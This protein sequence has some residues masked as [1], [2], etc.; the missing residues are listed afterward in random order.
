[1]K[2]FKRTFLLFLLII[3]VGFQEDNYERVSFYKLLANP[4]EYNGKKICLEGILHYR[5]ED[6]G[7]YPSQEYS[8]Y[9]ITESAFGIDYIKNPNVED[10]KGHQISL[11]D[12]NNKYVRISGVF[13]NNKHGHMGGFAGTIE[14]VNDVF[15]SINW[16]AQEKK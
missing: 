11:N 16:A 9:L 4:G 6:S 12:L 3:I 14:E 13:N 8:N 15:E 2:I 1:M 10:S 5:F 7:I